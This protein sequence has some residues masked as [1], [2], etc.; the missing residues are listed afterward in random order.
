MMSFV[1]HMGFDT[2]L[3]CG[4]VAGEDVTQGSDCVQT[5][6]AEYVGGKLLS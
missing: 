2:I 4:F 1:P 3:H 6:M 5:K